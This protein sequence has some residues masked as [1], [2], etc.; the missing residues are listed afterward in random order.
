MT[1]NTKKVTQRRDVSY[2]S[3]EDV[4]ADAEHLA[5]G[6]V[7][8]VGNWTLGQI[9][10]H[11]AQSMDSSI[12]GTEMK[13]PW[14]MKK[15]IRVVIN[16]EKILKEKLSPGF[17]IPKKGEAQFQPDPGVSSNCNYRCRWNR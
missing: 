16:K 13:F 1:V 10:K 17:K 11:L 14:L 3:Y 15:I 12:D 9:F 4:L 8:T 6:N 5:S 7:R 2:N